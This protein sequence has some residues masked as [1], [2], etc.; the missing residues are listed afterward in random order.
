[1]IADDFVRLMH[2]AHATE[3]ADPPQSL[4]PCWHTLIA[5]DAAGKSPDAADP[6]VEIA[7]WEYTAW[8][9]E[10]N[11]GQMAAG[12]ARICRAYADDTLTGI[13]E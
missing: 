10:E 2:L 8:A 3:V 1:M 6:L 12:F 4:A 9:A 7:F 5:L 13:A 11:F